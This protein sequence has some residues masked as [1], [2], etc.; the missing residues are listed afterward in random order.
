MLFTEPG[1]VEVVAGDYWKLSPKTLVDTPSK[2]EENCL[3]GEERMKSQAREANP[4]IAGS[5][6][7]VKR[8]PKRASMSTKT[9]TENSQ[10][11]GC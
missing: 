2:E 4:W 6:I 9:S 7:T 10:P 8:K 5:A 1:Y 11:D 3:H